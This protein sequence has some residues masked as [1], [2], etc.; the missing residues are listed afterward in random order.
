MILINATTLS[1]N[2]FGNSDFGQKYQKENILES[3]RQL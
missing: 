1:T 2:N 3:F